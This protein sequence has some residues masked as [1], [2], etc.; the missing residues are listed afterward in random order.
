MKKGFFKW[1]SVCFAM[2]FFCL[3]IS[4]CNNNKNSVAPGGIIMEGISSPNFRLNLRDANHEIIDELDYVGM[5]PVSEGLIYL[6]IPEDATW[7]E[8]GSYTVDFYWYEWDTQNIVRI[9]RIPDF[10]HI[11][12]GPVCI[13]GHLY[14]YVS[15]GNLN[16]EEHWL[17]LI[18]LDIENLTMTE[19]FSEKDGCPYNSMAAQGDRLL[20]GK[21]L[22]GNASYLEEYHT[23][24]GE[25]R[26]LLE[27]EFDT[28]TKMGDIIQSVASDGKT[29]SL[30]IL[31]SHGEDPYGLR[32]DVYDLDMNFLHSVDLSHISS[33]NNE[34]GQWMAWFVASGDMIYYENYSVTTFLGRIKNGKAER[35]LETTDDPGQYIFTTAIET[36]RDTQTGVFARLYDADEHYIYRMNYSDGSMERAAFCPEETGKRITGLWRDGNDNL[37]IEM[38]DK[39]H[40]IAQERETTMYRV[41]L[42]EL[43]FEPFL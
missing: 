2:I 12:T 40:S 10:A 37:L 7:T 4:G 28:E 20:M 15:T 34:L 1:L 35:V 42:S 9:G 17:K 23:K 21:V 8:Y 25:R 11:T 43:E 26:V 6:Y 27:A 39:E 13:D 18:D 3:C 38:N 29:I 30:I 36:Q 16:T 14:M 19:I 5:Y 33:D 22:T 32:M 24:T 41:P 31:E